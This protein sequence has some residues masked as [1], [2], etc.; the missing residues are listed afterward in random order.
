MKAGAARTAVGAGMA[1]TTTA[2]AGAATKTMA[3]AAIR[4][5]T[6]AYSKLRKAYR[7][8][9]FVF[10]RSEQD[11]LHRSCSRF[12]SPGGVPK[13]REFLR[14]APP[15]AEAARER[16]LPVVREGPCCAAA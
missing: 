11:R 9:A 12:F 16:S 2:S 7:K 3:T 10:R 8:R 1:R 14:A 4:T 6:E 15:C 5:S 13:E